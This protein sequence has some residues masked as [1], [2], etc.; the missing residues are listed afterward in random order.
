MLRSMAA[1][2]FLLAASLGALAGP[3]TLDPIAPVGPLQV[4]I[5]R[6]LLNVTLRIECMSALL[7]TAGGAHNPELTVLYEFTET[8]GV[9]ISGAQATRTSVDAC[10]TGA[11]ELV[12]TEHFDVAVTRPARGQVP[13][14]LHL[15]VEVQ[16]SVLGPEPAEATDEEDFTVEAAYLGYLSVDAMDRIFRMKGG[17]I[18][19]TVMQVTLHGN[20]DSHIVTTIEAPELKAAGGSVEASPIRLDWMDGE[21]PQGT[22]TVKVQAAS[23]GAHAA[24]LIFTPVSVHDGTEGT[25]DDVRLWVETHDSLQPTPM[26][27]HLL[28]VALA[29]AYWASRR[30]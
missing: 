11:S 12:L 18:K 16:K 30:K 3:V 5:E 7:W 25:P 21:E 27:L 2:L 29:L 28:V 22:L 10:H 24:R 4:D 15:Q 20:A 17:Q 23:K 9:I 13:L 6:G 1:V 26:P 19:E 8:D 14:P